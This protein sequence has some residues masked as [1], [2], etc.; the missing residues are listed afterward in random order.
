MPSVQDLPTRAERLA[1]TEPA[2]TAARFWYAKARV[3]KIIDTDPP[4]SRDQFIE[5][6]NDLLA[7]AGDPDA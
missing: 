4:L 5:L 7:A 3:R 1:A 6:A 2:R